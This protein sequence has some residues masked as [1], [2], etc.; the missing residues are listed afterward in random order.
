MARQKNA[1]AKRGRPPKNA[2]KKRGPGRPRK[3]R[4]AETAMGLAFGPSAVDQA[5]QD[6]QHALYAA[7]QAAHGPISPGALVAA[8][9][10]IRTYLVNG[11]SERKA[12]APAPI[13]ET[14]SSTNR[15]VPGTL[16]SHAVSPT[17][18]DSREE[19]TRNAAE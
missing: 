12:V 18:G 15:W 14:G 1:T 11:V 9:E 13:P 10:I 6:R 7:L 17:E 16:S 5:Q 3:V 19:T 2:V 4:G 8:S